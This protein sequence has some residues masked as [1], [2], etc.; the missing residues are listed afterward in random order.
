APM[1]EEWG[2]DDGQAAATRHAARLV[3]GLRLL[4]RELDAFNPDLVLM[5]GDDQYENFKKDCVPPFCIFI[6][7]EMKCMPLADLDRGAF[8]T[9]VNVW[10]LPSDTTIP[11]HGHKQAATG[12]TRYLLSNGFDVSYALQTRHEKGLSHS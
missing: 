12:L 10:G 2:D 9:P 4:R 11:V 5:W 7:E 8:R 1:I 6:Q 3:D